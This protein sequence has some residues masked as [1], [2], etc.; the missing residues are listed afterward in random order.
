MSELIQLHD[1]R[2]VGL[3]LQRRRKRHGWKQKQVADKLGVSI[4]RISY[5]ERTGAGDPAL[6]ERYALF[7]GVQ[8]VYG[9]REV[10][11]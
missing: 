7:L 8:V 1:R 5:L 4:A 9:I 3:E 6:L 11:A 2:D 10:A